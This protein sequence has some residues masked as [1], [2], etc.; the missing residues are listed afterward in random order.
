MVE[1]IERLQSIEIGD[2]VSLEVFSFVCHYSCTPRINLLDFIPLL[3]GNAV[4]SGKRFQLP[5]LAL[6]KIASKFSLL[7]LSVV[8]K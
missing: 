4:V 3:L 2:L 8:S 1:R 6:F 7:F 5:P